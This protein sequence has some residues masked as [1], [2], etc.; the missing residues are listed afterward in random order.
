MSY[1]SALKK[2]IE[3]KEM[4]EPFSVGTNL[5]DWGRGFDVMYEELKQDG[6]RFLESV[7]E[8]LRQGLCNQ[9]IMNLAD[10]IS[11]SSMQIIVLVIAAILKLPPQMES[12]SATVAAIVC[13]SGLK[14]FCR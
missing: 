8:D 10:E 12:I 6:T 14:E 5:A 13:R 2:A 11:S 9:D 4:Y 3:T 1:L 7:K